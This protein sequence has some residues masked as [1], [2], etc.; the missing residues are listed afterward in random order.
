[1]KR[2]VCQNSIFG[3]N[4]GLG[5][6]PFLGSKRGFAKPQ[7]EKQGLG[8]SRNFRVDK[9]VFQ[10]PIVGSGQLTLHSASELSLVKL[11]FRATG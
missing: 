6:T 2:G 11:S 7:S 10:T 4:G 1:M 9:R 8:K 3:S 5:Q